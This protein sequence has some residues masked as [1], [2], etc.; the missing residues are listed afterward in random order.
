MFECKKQ[1][2]KTAGKIHIAST[3]VLAAGIT[4][5]FSYAAVHAISIP[6]V[7]S[8]IIPIIHSQPQTLSI[9]WV[10]DM[11]PTENDAYNAHVFDAVAPYIQQS[12]LTIG[13]VEGTFAGENR[14]PKCSL[15]QNGCFS[16]RGND[17]FLDSLTNAGFDMV[18]FVNNHSL[19]FGKE[20]LQDTEAIADTHALS[21]ISQLHPT[22]EFIV[23][24][25]HIGVLGISSSPPDHRVSDYAYIANTIAD[26]KTRND[27]V[28]LIMH[29]GAEGASK[30]IVP[31]ATEYQGNENRGDVEKIAH[32]AIDAGADL[33]LGSGP[34]VLRKI[35]T[36][37]DGL[38]AYSLGN[39]EG[40]NGKLVTKGILGTS[41]ILNVTISKKDAIDPTKNIA[42]SYTFTSIALSRD[43]V[44]AIDPADTGKNLVEEL[45]ATNN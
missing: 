14:Y 35:E 19:D 13:N 7:A 45:N 37:Q 4:A 23:K 33:V 38:I 29:A 34:H 3:L 11:V 40:G 22:R 20:G 17:T 12:D 31:G 5:A 15:E 1:I 36:Y 25:F 24:N 32:T 26:L 39:F 8:N 44:P 18:S 43:G 16:F 42:P 2:Q 41:G 10:G 9:S 30:T 21:Y 27:V 28:I 6:D